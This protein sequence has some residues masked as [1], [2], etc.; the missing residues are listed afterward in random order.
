MPDQNTMDRF[1][2]H[3]ELSKYNQEIQASGK[4][5]L[6]PS[7]GSIEGGDFNLLYYCFHNQLH[8]FPL[9]FPY[10]DE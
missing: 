4:S 9:V 6:F 10:C 8:K 7:K 2:S 3:P 5:A 1:R